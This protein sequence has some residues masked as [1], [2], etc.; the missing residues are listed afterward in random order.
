MYFPSK[1]LTFIQTE[2]LVHQPNII[3]AERLGALLG[4]YDRRQSTFQTCP[5]IDGI[6]NRLMYVLQDAQLSTKELVEMA[7]GYKLGWDEV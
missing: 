1:T 5:T 3:S 7:K 4:N 2:L 6:L